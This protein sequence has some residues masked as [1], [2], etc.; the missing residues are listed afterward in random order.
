MN[1]V[2]AERFVERLDCDIYPITIVKFLLNKRRIISYFSRVAKGKYRINGMRYKMDHSDC[3]FCESKKE[4]GVLCRQHTSI[5]RIMEAESVA[6]D[7]DTQT[8]FY[9]NEIFRDIDGKLV[10]FY[11]PHPSLITG[12]ITDTKTRRVNITTIDDVNF[13][14]LPNYKN[15]YKFVSGELMDKQLKCW[16]NKDFSIVTLPAGRN[17]VNWCLIPNH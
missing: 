3:S 17:E 7:L 13:K 1:Y 10:I 16:F 9:K 14:G 12:S 8:Y 5:Q 4:K 15:V 2:S 6:F 11:C